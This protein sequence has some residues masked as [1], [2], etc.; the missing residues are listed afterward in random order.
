[1]RLLFNEL[2]CTQALPDMMPRPVLVPFPDI[3]VNNQQHFQLFLFINMV[4][5]A[6]RYNDVFRYSIFGYPM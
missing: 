3:G 5:D 1:L 2:F 6:L 4:L